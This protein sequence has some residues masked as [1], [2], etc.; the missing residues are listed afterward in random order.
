ME[1]TALE[2]V[3]WPIPFLVLT[4]LN[5]YGAD[6]LEPVT[7]PDKTGVVLPAFN[8]NGTEGSRT[9]DLADTSARS[10]NNFKFQMEPTRVE[11]VTF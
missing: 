11:L 2:P 6:L 1:R 7:C 4:A 3:K 10:P 9:T 8:L 5:L